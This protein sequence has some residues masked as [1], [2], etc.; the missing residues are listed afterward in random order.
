MDGLKVCRKWKKEY[1]KRNRRNCHHAVPKSVQFI[2]KIC[3]CGK[4][5]CDLREC[6]QFTVN[7]C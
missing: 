4:K 2:A 1:R 7:T 5:M 6:N 3:I